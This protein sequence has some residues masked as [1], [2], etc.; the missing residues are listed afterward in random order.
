MNYEDEINSKNMSNWINKYKNKC[1]S[2]KY[3]T[4]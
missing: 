4:Y 3:T 1:I 2:K